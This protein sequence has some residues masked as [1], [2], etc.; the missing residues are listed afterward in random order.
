M[1]VEDGARCAQAPHER[2]ERV[3]G[4]LVCRRGFGN[5]GA[6]VARHEDG[7]AD[8]RTEGIGEGENLKGDRACAYGEQTASKDDKEVVRL[9]A[10]LPIAVT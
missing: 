8:I 1:A 6:G 10:L 2:G 7:T 5:H 9:P 4:R 3:P